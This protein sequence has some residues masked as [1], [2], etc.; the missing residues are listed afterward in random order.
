M[1]NLYLITKEP[2]LGDFLQQG[3]IERNI[4]LNWD[5][6]FKFLVICCIVSLVGSLIIK[7]NPNKIVKNRPRRDS[8]NREEQNGYK[9][10]NGCGSNCE[11]DCYKRNDKN[12]IIKDSAGNPLTNF[13]KL[14]CRNCRNNT[15]CMCCDRGDLDGGIVN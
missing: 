11:R 4:D 7:P 5:F 13:N 8:P 2:T 1:I 6:W 15:W 9:A 3:I 10:G 14:K 12:E